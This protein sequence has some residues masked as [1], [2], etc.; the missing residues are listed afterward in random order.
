MV[1]AKVV[2]TTTSGKCYLEM[3]ICSGHTCENSV[4]LAGIGVRPQE[5]QGLP[6]GHDNLLKFG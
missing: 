4:N 3:H 5:L 1:S 6:P 2:A